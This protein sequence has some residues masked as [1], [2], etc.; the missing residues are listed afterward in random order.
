[1]DIISFPDSQGRGWVWEWDHMVCNLIRRLSRWRLGLGSL[2][3]RP[4]RGKGPGDTWQ[5][6]PYVLSQSIM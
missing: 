3:P 5:V 6:F 2:V 4:T 1:L